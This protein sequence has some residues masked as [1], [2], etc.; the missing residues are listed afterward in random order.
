MI[1]RDD[2]SIEQQAVQG[3]HASIEMART[4]MNKQEEI[5]HLVF[6]NTTIERLEFLIEKL[7]F[8]GITFSE[9]YEPDIGNKLTAIATVPIYGKDRKVFSNLKLLKQEVA[10]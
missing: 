8:K 7:K 4:Y 6:C 1:A 10:V 2:L 5:P 9:F 3:C